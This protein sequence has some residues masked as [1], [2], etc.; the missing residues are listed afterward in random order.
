MF[1]INDTTR[2][3]A[4]YIFLRTVST[5]AEA[6]PTENKASFDA[7]IATVKREIREFTRR[8]ASDSRIVEERGCDGYIELVQLPEELDRAHKIA[9]ANWFRAN[10]YLEFFPTFY[11]CSGQKFTNRFKLFRRRGHWFAYHFVSFDM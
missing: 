3:R 7:L 5:E 2:L 6:I 10:R 1:D 8:P 9:A 11:D 4:A